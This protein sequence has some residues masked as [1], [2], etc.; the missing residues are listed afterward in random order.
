MGSARRVSLK[1]NLR[2]YMKDEEN[3]VL[4]DVKVE[5][6]NDPFTG[7]GEKT[8]SESLPEKTPEEVKPDQ[9]VNTDDL[10][11][12]NTPF[13]KHPRW[14]ERENELKTLKEREAARAAADEAREREIAEL[15]QFK[16]ETSH[17]LAPKSGKEMAP[18]FKTLYGDNPEAWEQY[19]EH[20]K[21]VREQLKQEVFEAHEQKIQEAQE[22]EKYWLNWVDTEMGKL[23]AKGYKFDRE[24]LA[25]VMMR[26]RPTDEKGNLDFEAGYETYIA[27]KGPTVNPQVSQARKQVADT[28][29]RTSK[30]EPAKKDY[31]TSAE[32]RNKTWGSL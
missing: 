13:H 17:K 28:V 8:P 25:Q 24:E 32:L 20:D 11:D 16:E 19:L 3:S 29:N 18:W 23:E 22:Q 12:I 31:M 30:G 1:T 6:D 10:D 7:L 26:T 2:K 14:I 15:K 27:R 9:G 5:G 21:E 4:A